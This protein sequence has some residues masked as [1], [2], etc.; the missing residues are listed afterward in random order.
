MGDE[1]FEEVENDGSGENQLRADAENQRRIKKVTEWN[2]E[3]TV[4][5]TNV[6]DA[7]IKKHKINMDLYYVDSFKV[8]DGSWDTSAIKR[9][10]N[11]KWTCPKDEEGNPVGQYMEGTSIR[12][13]EFMVNNNKTNY[14]E[15]TF[16]RKPI[17]ADILESYKE[18]MKE[19]P[20]LPLL[21]H[22]AVPIQKQTGV[23]AEIAIYDPHFGKLAWKDETGYRHY[24]TKIAAKDYS[25][26]TSRCLD[27][28]S[29]H[30][31]EKIFYVVGQDLYHI[32]NMESHTTNGD[33]TMDVDGRITKIHKIV[34]ENVR[35]A[36]YKASTLAPVEVIWIPGNHDFLAS[37]MLVFA[38]K[39]HFK[40]Y[41]RVTVDISE[42]PRKARLWGNLLVGWTHR[43]VGKHTVWS[44]ELAQAFPEL[45][46]K[47]MF[48]EW[49]HGD[50]HKK[51]NVKVTPLFTSGGV[52][53]RQVTALSPVDQWHTTNVFTDAVPGGELFLWSKEVG[54]Y[55]NFTAWTGQYEKKNI[56]NLKTSK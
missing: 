15:I 6:I 39:E 21:K 44:N 51:Q 48:R 29:P 49:H 52:I 19:M 1:Y 4:G 17:E 7:I 55:A 41:K 5:S 46:G 20:V 37:Y 54:I 13:P 43:I 32:D 24:D 40:D 28:A 2:P 42:N 12:Y 38:L 10:Q 16:K 35:N 8:K 56:N 36:I 14:V 31:P 26:V 47:S 30:K 9:D 45:W 18:I 11:L 25:D 53:C 3:Q 27:L 23:A 22:R 33:H 50:Q 34:F